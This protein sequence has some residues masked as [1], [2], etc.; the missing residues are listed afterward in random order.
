RVA[1]ESI[2]ERAGEIAL[3]HFRR[4]TPERKSDRSLVTAA[5]REV[6]AY[7]ASALAAQCPGV[8]IVGEEGTVVEGRG[9]GRFF[10]DPIDGSPASRPGASASVWCRTGRRRPGSSISPAP[11]SAT[12]RS[13]ERPGGTARGW[14]RWTTY[15][16]P[17]TRSWSRTPGRIAATVW[18][19]SASSDRSDRRPPPR[20][21]SLP[22][23]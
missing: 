10:V 22:A 14:R 13:A 12:A 20:L 18:T 11:A 2:A 1:L 6:E 15:R 21:A 23:P 3:A 7:I 19:A 17:V 16:R 4:V 5:D 9:D 8:G